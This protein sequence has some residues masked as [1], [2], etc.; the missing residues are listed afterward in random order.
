[1][2]GFLSKKKIAK[3]EHLIL[4]RIYFYHYANRVIFSNRT[5]GLIF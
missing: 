3:V 4:F 2:G 5:H 1:M